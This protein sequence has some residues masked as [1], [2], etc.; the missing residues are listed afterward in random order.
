M[1]EIVEDG[2]NAPVKRSFEIYVNP[3]AGNHTPV[4]TSEPSRN[5][6]LPLDASG[7]SNPDPVF[8]NSISVTLGEETRTFQVGISRSALGV[9]TADIVIVLDVTGSMGYDLDGPN[10]PARDA[11]SWLWDGVDSVIEQ[12]ENKLS[13]Y[14]FEQNRYGLIMFDSLS[15][16]PAIVNGQ[17][18]A[19]RQ[20]AIAL[21]LVGTTSQPIDQ[22][23]LANSPED[24][25][26][27]A[28]QLKLALSGIDTSQ[29]DLFEI[30]HLAIQRLFQLQPPYIATPS[31]L[32]QQYPY[33]F[34][35]DAVSQV[36]L[37]SDDTVNEFNPALQR[38]IIS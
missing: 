21:G 20:M 10:G 30:G 13:E 18:V 33:S 34:R 2:F 28:A 1:E 17:Q 35:G 5:Y 16:I 27:T 25:W 4:I 29:T 14:G 24:L 3:I 26:G 31:G 15:Q 9:L 36:V 32:K 38:S 11:I 23:P 6:Q 22:I 8:P 12:I 37:I 19:N 7:Y